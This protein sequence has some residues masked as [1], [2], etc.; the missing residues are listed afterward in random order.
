MAIDESLVEKLIFRGRIVIMAILGRNI[1]DQHGPYIEFCV[2]DTPFNEEWPI[3]ATYEGGI[4]IEIAGDLL[5]IYCGLTQSYSPFDP[6]GFTQLERPHDIYEFT[7]KLLMW[8]LQLAKTPENYFLKNLENFE[9]DHNHLK[10]EENSV[11][12]LKA[13]LLETLHFLI[14]EMHKAAVSG[15]CVV[16]VGL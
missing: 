4:F 1:L 15:K 3:R 13:D 8:E 2:V 10:G 7:A 5:G 6:D 9:S 16:I 11:A 12:R 14:S